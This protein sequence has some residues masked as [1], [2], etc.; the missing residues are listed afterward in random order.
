M[1]ADGGQPTEVEALL[2]DLDPTVMPTKGGRVTQTDP[3]ARMANQRRVN[4]DLA[5][6]LGCS[7]SSPG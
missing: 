2:K 3:P 7:A 5:V 1:G 6:M 4:Y